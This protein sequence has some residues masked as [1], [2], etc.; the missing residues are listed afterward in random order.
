MGPQVRETRVAICF[1][2]LTEEMKDTEIVQINVTF[3]H[4]GASS[5]LNKA[6]I[7]C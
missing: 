3:I 6:L 1:T 4:L 5:E 2:L 7:L